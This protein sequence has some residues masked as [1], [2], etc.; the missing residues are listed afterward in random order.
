MAHILYA[1]ISSNIDLFSNSF[2]CQT[3][4]NNNNR[5]LK[6]VLVDFVHGFMTTLLFG[7]D[8]LASMGL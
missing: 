8:Q 3:R 7:V 2:H 4:V 1:F 5:R 6:L